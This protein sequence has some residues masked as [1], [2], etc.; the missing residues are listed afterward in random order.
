MPLDVE[1]LRDFQI[2][3]IIEIPTKNGVMVF[4]KFVAENFRYVFTTFLR[5]TLHL[6]LERF[7]YLGRSL[8]MYVHGGECPSS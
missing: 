6:L 1:W 7:G 8:L 2:A 5:S 3:V 4:S